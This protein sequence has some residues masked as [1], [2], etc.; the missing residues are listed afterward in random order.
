MAEEVGVSSSQL[1][2][3]KTTFRCD[4]KNLLMQNICSRYDPLD[5]SVDK[6]ALERTNHVYTHK[7]R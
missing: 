3:L 1:S 7:V 6:K 4:T 2:R 5:I